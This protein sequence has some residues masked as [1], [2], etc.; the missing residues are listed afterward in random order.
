MGIRTTNWDVTEHLKTDEDRAAYL[1]AVL[2]DADPALIAT[3]LGDLAKAAG[4]S[5]IARKTGLSRESLY[6]THSPEGNPGFATILKVMKALHLELHVTP[7]SGA[8][9]STHA[10]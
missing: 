8:S 9:P 10:V 4:M 5:Q 3:A 1:E 7:R 2:E 6:K